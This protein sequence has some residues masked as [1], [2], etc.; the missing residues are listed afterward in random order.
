MANSKTKKKFPIRFARL[1]DGSR[2][3]IVAEPSRG[4]RKS[5]DERVYVKVSDAWSHVEGDENQAII[6]YPEDVVLP[7]ARGE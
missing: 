2:F 7:L 6:L 4:I 5:Y 3:R 1:F